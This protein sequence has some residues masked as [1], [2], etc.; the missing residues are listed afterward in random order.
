MRVSTR[1]WSLALVV[2]AAAVQLGAQQA[3]EGNGHQWTIVVHGG[4]GVIERALLGPEGDPAYRASPTKGIEAG[5]KVL[6]SGGSAVDAVEAVLKVFEDDPL[7]NAAR[8]AVFTSE[9]KHELDASIMDGS[10]LM[11]GA[12]AGVTHTRYSIALERAVMDQSPYVM[13]AGPG[14]EAFG[15][16]GRLAHSWR[17]DVCVESFVRGFGDRIGR[18]LY[19]AGR[20]ARDQQ[21]GRIQGHGGAAG[22]R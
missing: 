16:R 19:P 17:R 18:V 7:F 1:A 5:S 9:G 15:A 2:G 12:V 4:A 14:A 21:S 10:S 20:G 13:M 3:K 22:G 6:D 11:A 8:G